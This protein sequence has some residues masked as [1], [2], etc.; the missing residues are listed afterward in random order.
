MRCVSRITIIT[1]ACALASGV[2]VSATGAASA[3]VRTR[4]AAAMPHQS[5]SFTGVRG[6]ATRIT[7]DTRVAAVPRP[8]ITAAGVAPEGLLFPDSTT[9]PIAPSAAALP[10][11]AVQGAAASHV[12]AKSLTVRSAA[13]L[14]RTINGLSELD[15]AAVNNG[16]E[17]TPPDQALCSGR[18]PSRAG[19]PMVVF[20]GVNLAIREMTPG[21]TQI[22]PDLNLSQLFRDP[23]QEGDI[24]CFWDPFTRT[25]FFTEIGFPLATGPSSS[26]ENT[27]VDIAVLNQRGIASYQFDTSLGGNCLGDQP[28][29][30]FNLDAVIVSTNEFCGT[31]MNFQ[32]PIVLVISKLQ[33][34]LEAAKVNEVTIPNVSLPGN[35]AISLDP[36]HGPGISTAYLVNSFP[37]TAAGARNL[38]ATSLGL[39]T[40]SNTISVTLGKGTPVLTGTVIP[41][42]TYAFPVRAAST[43]S[44]AVVRVVPGTLNGQPHDFPITSEAFLAP[45]DSRLNSGIEAVP[46]F[47]HIQLYA[48]LESSLTP[49]GDTAVRDGVAWFQID[50][51]GQRVVNQGYVAA[52]GTYLLYPVIAKSQHGSPTVGFSLTSPAINPSS[53]FS[54]AGSDSITI[55]AAGAGPHLSFSDAPPFNRAR[56][57]DYSAASVLPDDSGIWFAEEYIPPVSD[58]ADRDNWGTS[59]FETSG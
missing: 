35:L 28:Q 38:D 59:V 32:G 53:G 24:R 56:W 27:T 5:A 33:L 39:W 1:F 26:L 47:G 17:V 44:G 43:G 18:D 48:A 51:A 40:I 45:D 11:S 16:G 34:V 58:Q 15:S 23:F 54:T 10:G 6:V 42:E 13:H 9:G 22:R 3:Q 14:L 31:P 7:A 20:E 57:G 4:S 19:N 29:V 37:F 12:T 55:V 2:I 25:F 50:A 30:G 52:S 46:V 49:A 8:A 41:S 36:A 21:G